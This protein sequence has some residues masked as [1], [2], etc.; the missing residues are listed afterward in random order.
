MDLI[1]N[2]SALVQLMAGRLSGDNPLYEPMT[3]VHLR[4]DELTHAIFPEFNKL[5]YASG[6]YVV[7]T[8][9]YN[10]QYSH[11][12]IPGNTCAAFAKYFFGI[13]EIT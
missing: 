4:I 6:E 9:W 3:H 5:S 2:N 11:N 1:N 10:M 13:V 7:L 12:I 8:L